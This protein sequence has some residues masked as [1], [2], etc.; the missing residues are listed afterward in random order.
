MAK[1][2]KLV[3]NAKRATLVQRH[4]AKRAALKATINSPKSTP[5][6]GCRWRRRA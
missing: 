6:P 2:S 4:A 5:G 3:Q 1:T